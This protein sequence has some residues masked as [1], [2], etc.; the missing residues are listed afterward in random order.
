MM[1]KILNRIS[2]VENDGHKP[3][4]Y[5]AW[6]RYLARL[7]QW[8]C[9]RCRGSRRA[10]RAQ[11]QGRSPLLQSSS[12]E[13]QM[14]LYFGS[15]AVVSSLI[16]YFKSIVFAQIIFGRFPKPELFGV[17]RKKTG[18]DGGAMLKKQ[19]LLSHPKKPVWFGL[20]WCGIIWDWYWIVKGHRG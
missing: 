7:T 12:C 4:Y 8:P 6:R 5:N 18:K 14:F 1:I 17:K 16:F 2:F 11:R 20:V 3:N 9:R 19:L 10:Q 13:Y 15:C